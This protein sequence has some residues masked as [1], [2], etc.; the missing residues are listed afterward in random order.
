MLITIALLDLAD[1]V[2][3]EERSAHVLVELHEL[4]RQRIPESRTPSAIFDLPALDPDD[5]FDY[6]RV[7]G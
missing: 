3:V 4:Y 6:V 7:D 5:M 1:T 2:T